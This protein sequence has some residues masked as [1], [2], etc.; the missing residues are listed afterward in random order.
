MKKVIIIAALFL[1]SI[2][3]FGSEKPKNIE[4]EVNVEKWM[5]VPFIDAPISLETWMTKL[6]YKTPDGPLQISG[7]ALNG[8][9]YKIVLTEETYPYNGKI[10]EVYKV[11]YKNKSVKICV[12]KDKSFI[13][14]DKDIVIIY[15]Y[16]SGNF[17]MIRILFNNREAQ[18]N[19]DHIEYR[20]QTEL[21]KKKMNTIEA[22]TLIVDNF[23]LLKK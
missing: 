16:T 2:S 11:N 6:F 14:L 23:P 21:N 15:G 18:K 3:I 22:I 7:V 13:V 1:M 5:T 19:I 10:Y 20:R 9:P 12:Y 17:G 4:R 8:E